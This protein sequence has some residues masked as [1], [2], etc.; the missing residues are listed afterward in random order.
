MAGAQLLDALGN[1]ILDASGN[2]MLDDG[3]GNACCCDTNPCLTCPVTDPAL[4]C[5]PCGTCTP[6]AIL[7]TFS[8][9]TAC[10]CAQNGFSS[11]TFSANPN[12]TFCVPVFSGGTVCQWKAAGTVTGVEWQ[13]GDCTGVSN[14]YTSEFLVD[15]TPVG[16]FK[17]WYWISGSFVRDGAIFVYEATDTSFATCVTE[18]TFANQNPTPCGASTGGKF[19]TVATGGTVTITLC[20]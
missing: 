11:W 9:I 8:G 17:V 10:G 4:K 15:R 19:Q 12:G 7:L 3:A 5:T 14:T 18:G 13:S 6:S 16:G 20:C 2:V 1:A